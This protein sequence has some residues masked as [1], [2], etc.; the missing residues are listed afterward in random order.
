MTKNSKIGMSI[1][2]ILFFVV[3][4]IGVFRQ[5]SREPSYFLNVT[6]SDIGT[7]QIGDDVSIQGVKT[8]KV[9]SINIIDSLL[10]VKIELPKKVRI[11]KGSDFQLINLGLLGEKAIG[12]VRTNSHEYYS[13]NDT[14]SGSS[15][16]PISIGKAIGELT[17]QISISSKLDSVIILLNKQNQL[18][19]QS[20][21]TKR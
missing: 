19:E 7:L 10:L 13:S 3:I 11:P 5:L 12:I 4:V 1:L 6:F 16:N 14:I 17:N 21:K 8:G 9:K 18:I 2:L 15:P 20:I